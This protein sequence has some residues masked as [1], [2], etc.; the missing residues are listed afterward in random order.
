MVMRRDLQPKSRGAL[1]GVALGL[2]FGCVGVLSFGCAQPSPAQSPEPKTDE[3]VAEP[4]PE[5]APVEE[6]VESTPQDE[7]AEP[8]VAS[9]PSGPAPTELV[10]EL[11][12]EICSRVKKSCS[13][14]A[15]DFCNASCGDYVTGAEKCPTEVHAALHCQTSADDFLLCSNIAAESCAPLYREMTD[16]RNGVSSPKPWGQKSEPKTDENVPSGFARLTVDAG[17]FSN[18]APVGAKVNPLDGGLFKAE[19]ENEGFRYVIE[20]VSVDNDQKPDAKTLLR[21]TTKYVGNDCQPKLRLHGRYET[22]GVVHTRFD[23]VCKDGT[24]IRGMMHFWEKSIVAISVRRDEPGKA[25]PNLEPFI[26]SFERST[27]SSSR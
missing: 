17:G 11:C 3:P 15:A 6:P 8:G 12:S 7:W 13:S 18:L 23:T 2:A 5:P 21:A 26:F 9:E 19:A 25:N 16:C 4:E 1:P 22:Q 24:E 27:T 10:G 14:R 20:A